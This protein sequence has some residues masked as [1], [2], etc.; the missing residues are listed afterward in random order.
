MKTK[1]NP[2]YRQFNCRV[3]DDQY[4]DLSRQSWSTNQSI[5]ALVRAALEEMKI[6]S[7]SI[8]KIS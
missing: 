8:N 2:R 4:R 1:K 7:P 3:T 5:S 6:I